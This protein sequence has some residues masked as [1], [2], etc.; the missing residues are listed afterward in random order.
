[1]PG[2]GGGTGGAD[3]DY[4]EGMG[5]KGAAAADHSIGMGAGAGAASSDTS[6]E[7]FREAIARAMVGYVDQD[8][9]DTAK[10]EQDAIDAAVAA[11][12]RALKEAEAQQERQAMMDQI[13]AM[14][15]ETTFATPATQAVPTE[16]DPQNPYDIED[17]DVIDN[18]G[19]TL[20][21]SQF[22]DETN[23]DPVS[24]DSNPVGPT[25]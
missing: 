24:P 17:P 1:M 18:K 16:F 20:D 21:E 8:V 2:Y 4:G 12:D 11:R 7:A 22:N 13:D 9:R 10:A 15:K 3:A 5:T 14:Q 19:W 25:R 23:T 6:I